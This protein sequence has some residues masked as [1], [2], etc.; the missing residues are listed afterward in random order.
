MGFLGWKNLMMK[1]GELSC[2][3][4][5]TFLNNLKKQCIAIAI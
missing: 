5:C 4:G 2:V 3:T 1:A